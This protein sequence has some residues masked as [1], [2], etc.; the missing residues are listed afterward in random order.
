MRGQCWCKDQG[1]VWALNDYVL[2]PQPKYL[3]G[4]SLQLSIR[5][6]HDK[7]DWQCIAPCSLVEDISGL[8]KGKQI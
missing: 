4:R 7:C 8:I 2:G 3:I 5:K 1:K 6:E